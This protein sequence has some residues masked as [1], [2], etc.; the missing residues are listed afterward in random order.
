MKEK[1]DYINITKVQANNSNNINIKIPTEALSM[2][3]LRSFFRNASNLR[4]Q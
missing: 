4:V 1:Q 2:H 3:N